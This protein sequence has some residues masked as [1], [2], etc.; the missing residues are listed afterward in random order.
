LIYSDSD[1]VANACEAMEGSGC[2]R[3]WVRNVELDSGFVKDRPGLEPGPHV[4]F[5]VEDD[6]PTNFLG[7]G[8][9]MA[10]V[11]GIVRNHE[12]WIDVD[13]RSDNGTTVRIYLPGA[14]GTGIR[15]KSIPPRRDSRKHARRAKLLAPCTPS[16]PCD[17]KPILAPRLPFRSVLQPLTSNILSAG[18]P[19]SFL[20][21]S[22]GKV[23]N[24]YN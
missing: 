22:Q 16:A 9:G 3:I 2:I 5:C 8:L 18:T 17:Y 4:C 13:S 20:S 15:K 7:R 23:N 14:P 11:Y 21:A 12:G 6:G 10:S 19:S 1:L 24:V